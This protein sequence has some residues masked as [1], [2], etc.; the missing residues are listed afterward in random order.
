MVVTEPLIECRRSAIRH[1]REVLDWRV[2]IFLFEGVLRHVHR[3]ETKP[4]IF[5]IGEN[6]VGVPDNANAIIDRADSN[7]LVEGGIACVLGE[8][9][10]MTNASSYLAI[11]ALCVC[12]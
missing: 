7:F 4:C 8:H 9:P 11:G 3:D 1:E 10:P 2:W 6:G 5:L 12:V